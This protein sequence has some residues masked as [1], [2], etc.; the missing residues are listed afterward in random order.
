MAAMTYGGDMSQHI[1]EKTKI[2][3]LWFVIAIFSIVPG[4]AW[5]VSTDNK[6]T[7]AKAETNEIKSEIPVI[8]N[9][10]IDIRERLIRIEDVLN[11]NR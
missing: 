6:A 5:M 1:D 8:K 9:S 2:P 11:Q 10:L 7:E 3:L 4:I